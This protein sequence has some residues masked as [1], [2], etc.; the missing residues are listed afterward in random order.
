MKLKMKYIYNELKHSVF[1]KLYCVHNTRSSI[2]IQDYYRYINILLSKE[3]VNTYKII[4]K[5]VYKEIGVSK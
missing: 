1:S 2:Y 5:K 4:E 3:E